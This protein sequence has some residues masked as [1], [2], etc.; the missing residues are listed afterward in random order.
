MELILDTPGAQLSKQGAM[1]LLEDGQRKL[2]VAAGRVRS[3]LISDSARLSSDALILLLENGADVLLLDDTGDVAGRISQPVFG[4]TVR[5]R[6]AQLAWSSTPAA[7]VWMRRNMAIRFETMQRVLAPYLRNRPLKE[8]PLTD[9]LGAIDR[10]QA[11]CDALPATQ[12]N[13]ATRASLRGYEGTAARAYFQVISLLLPE[14]YRFAQRSRR[15]A[16]DP[17]NALLNYLYGILYGR[18]ETAMIRAGLDPAIG[19]FHAERHQRDVFTYDLIERYRC[20]AEHLAISICIGR[21]LLPDM[22]SQREGGG[23]WLEQG[24]RRLAIAE[25][26]DYLAEIIQYKGKRRSRNTHLLHD[27]QEV[28]QTV[29]QWAA[30]NLSAEDE[31]PSE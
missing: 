23:I 10:M 25:M 20:W 6:R 19:V 16:L 24:G 7:G 30:L 13:A 14:A 2:K 27:C 12:W 15:P 26:N 11:Q 8:A 31:M 3:V 18:I 17:F 9:A 4:S 5:I 28:A 29:L 1:L 21:R 22:Y